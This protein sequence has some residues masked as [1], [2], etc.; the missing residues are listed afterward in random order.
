MVLPP[1]EYQMN[2]KDYHLAQLNIAHVRFALDDPRMADF[3]AGLDR[4]NALAEATPG[5]VWR[6]Q[7]ASGNATDIQAFDDP[8]L[9]VNMSVWESIDALAAYVYKSGHVDFLRRRKEWFATAE[10][11]FQVLWWVDAGHIPTVNAAKARL[12]YLTEHGP[13]A[14][15][16]TFRAPFA[17]VEHPSNDSP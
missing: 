12:E 9:L 6:L 13:T 15:A 16:F 5:F 11:P 7:S 17:P 3:M 14:Y 2:T 1:Y 10:T 4:I 8:R